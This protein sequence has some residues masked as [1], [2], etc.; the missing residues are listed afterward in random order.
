MRIWNERLEA[1]FFWLSV[2]TNIDDL[3]SG[4]DVRSHFPANRLRVKYR[5]LCLKMDFCSIKKLI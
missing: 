5:Y 4:Q 2:Y 3:L 1:L